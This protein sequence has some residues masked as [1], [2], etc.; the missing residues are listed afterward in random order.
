MVECRGEA[1]STAARGA[2]GT[3]LLRPMGERGDR[4]GTS[5]VDEVTAYFAQVLRRGQLEEVTFRDGTP[6]VTTPR[7]Q[8]LQGT[9]AEEDA[10]ALFAHHDRSAPRRK[11]GTPKRDAALSVVISLATL[12][13]DR[14]E[15][16]DGLLLLS[17]TLHR[18]GRL[19]PDLETATSPWIPSER[20]SS[21]AVTDREVMVR[22]TT[23]GRTR[24]PRSPRRS[25]APPRCAGP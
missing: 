9:L 25:R 8:I 4:V 11:D 17:A 14:G 16:Q 1:V 24:A 12:P 3:G 21:P 23:S 19:E 6:F 2:R 13:S 18:D 10:A 22:S 15:V 5:T 20:L 7:D